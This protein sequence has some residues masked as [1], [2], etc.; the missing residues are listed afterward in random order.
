M[1]RMFRDARSKRRTAPMYASTTRTRKWEA[2]VESSSPTREMIHG[3][4][5]V[6]RRPARPNRRIPCRHSPRIFP[7]L[8]RRHDAGASAP[9]RSRDR[10]LSAEQQ[11]YRRSR[12]RDRATL[13][14]DA[15]ALLATIKENKANGYITHPRPDR[16]GARR[17]RAHHIVH[18]DIVRSR[19][20]R[21]A[22]GG[23]RARAQSVCGVVKA[24]GDALDH[25]HIPLD[26]ASAERLKCFL[27]GGRVMAGD[28]L[29]DTVELDQHHALID[30]GLI[31]FR[32]VAAR[33]EAAAGRLDR[34]HC[35][36]G[37]GLP[38]FRTFHRTIGHHPI[39]LR[40]LA[41]SLL[42]VLAVSLAKTYGVM[43][44]RSKARASSVP[45]SGR[46]VRRVTFQPSLPRLSSQRLAPTR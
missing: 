27:V 4:R 41:H 16:A 15:D 5:P 7:S 34:R 1:E 12:A 17:L 35:K 13:S 30:A 40:H 25:A 45:S 33:Q 8:C 44:R 32:R 18:R 6:R 2:P 39:S 21:A 43:A 46:R 9:G 37:I 23:G 26:I 24:L 22:P 3:L 42:F 14:F 38:R 36:F 10:A 31:D 29:V 20:R 19:C 11:I 28:R